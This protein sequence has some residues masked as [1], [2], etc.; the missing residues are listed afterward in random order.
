M[1]IQNTLH[2]GSDK[3]ASL[4]RERTYSKLAG[5]MHSN[6]NASDFT[7]CDFLRK[8]LNIVFHDAF[9]ACF[10]GFTDL[11]KQVICAVLSSSEIPSADNPTLIKNLC[12]TSEAKLLE[13][14]FK[15]SL[16]SP[17]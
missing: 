4:L 6:F 13:L 3:L 12:I 17:T 16:S 7:N 8:K 2:L 11:R 15:S 1:P 10:H 5:G 9:G 14:R